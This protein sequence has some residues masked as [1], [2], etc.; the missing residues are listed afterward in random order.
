MAALKSVIAWIDRRFP[1]TTFIRRE[2]AEYPT[3]RNLS[4]W[5]GFG[6]LAGFL[7]LV[8]I[9]SGVFLAMHYKHGRASRL[10]LGAAHHARRQLRLAAALSAFHRRLGIFHRDLYPHGAHALLRFLSRAARTHVVERADSA[11]PA[12]G[13]RL[14]GLS[15]AVGTDVV[16]GRAGHHQSVRR[17]A[18]DRR[19]GGVVAARRLRGGRRH[20]QS[21]L[22]SALPGAVRQ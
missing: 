7:L 17:H 19:R 14:H 12:D 22:R 15:A 9:V 16:L 4:Y 11:D 3:P 8:Q 5:W 10:R 20:P 13:Q 2:L 1:L 21:F 6:F 18:A